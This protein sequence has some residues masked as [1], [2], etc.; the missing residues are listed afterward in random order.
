[1]FAM[2]ALINTFALKNLFHYS[3]QDEYAGEAH[4]GQEHLGYPFVPDR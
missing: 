3:P 2:V 4:Q 1:M